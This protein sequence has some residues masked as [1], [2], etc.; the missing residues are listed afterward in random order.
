MKLK[1]LQTI[2]AEELASQPLPPPSFIVDG[3]IP[4]GLCVLAGPSKCG[5]SWL[6]LWLCMRV[7]QGLPIWELSRDGDQL[8]ELGDHIG[9]TGDRFLALEKI[10]DRMQGFEG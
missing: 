5:K 7:S 2:D 1:E 9:M 4:Y 10:M 3:L 6:M 8:M